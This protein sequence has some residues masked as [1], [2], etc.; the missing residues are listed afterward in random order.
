MAKKKNK[1]PLKQS[2]LPASAD[3]L[4]QDFI[5]DIDA[6]VQQTSGG[7][8]WEKQAALYRQEALK[9][10]LTAF[11]IRNVFTDAI[12]QQ[13][14][15][16]QIRDTQLKD[17][18]DNNPEIDESLL[19]P[20]IED[21]ATDIMKSGNMTYREV[22]G[23]LA[24]MNVN[25]PDYDKL[26]KQ[27]NTI[28]NNSAQLKLD[29]TKL[30]A[31]KNEIKA[32]G[33]EKF[34][35]G[36][37]SEKRLMYEDIMYG[38]GE[39]FKNIDGKLVWQNPGTKEIIGI[40]ETKSTEFDAGSLENKLKQINNP[41]ISYLDKSLSNPSRDGKSTHKDLHLEGIINPTEEYAMRLQQHLVNLGYNLGTTGDNNDGVDGDWGKLSKAA[42]KLYLEEREKGTGKIGSLIDDYRKGQFSVT[43]TGEYEPIEVSSMSGDINSIMPDK[44]AENESFKLQMQVRNLQT[45]DKSQMMYRIGIM[46]DEI[47][48]S[49]IKSLLFDGRKVILPNGQAKIGTGLHGL[50]DT[51]PFFEEWYAANGITSEEDKLKEYNRIR[52]EGIG[53]LGTNGVSV[54]DAFAEWYHDKVLLPQKGG[55]NISL[56]GD[57][58]S[59]TDVSST[60]VSGTDASGDTKST[61][62]SNI[63]AKFSY[64]G[65]DYTSNVHPMQTGGDFEPF[66]SSKESFGTYKFNTNDD[67]AYF[68][69]ST[70]GKRTTYTTPISGNLMEINRRNY[71]YDPTTEKWYFTGYLKEGGKWATTRKIIEIASNKWSTHGLNKEME[72]WG[73]YENQKKIFNSVLPKSDL[74][75][76]NIEGGMEKDDQTVIQVPWFKDPLYVKYTGKINGKHAYLIATNNADLNST[77]GMDAKIVNGQVVAGDSG[78]ALVAGD[79]RKAIGIPQHWLLSQKKSD[80][81]TSLDAGIYHKW[82]TPYKKEEK[83]VSKRKVKTSGKYH[84]ALSTAVIEDDFLYFD[85]KLHP[86]FKKA[87]NDGEFTEQEIIDIVDKVPGLV[88]A[89]NNIPLYRQ[90]DYDKYKKLKLRFL[91]TFDNDMFIK[92]LNAAV[93]KKYRI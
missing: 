10:V 34:T 88:F 30:L 5:G 63:N 70:D 35:E 89:Y 93:A 75:R 90:S 57:D 59:S 49:G 22:V 6:Y 39:N 1:T 81:K 56:V 45:W 40:D 82:K 53:V 87:I 42:M 72:A 46:F 23:K 44:L 61:T 33:F 78:M 37:N 71:L 24:G 7:N 54:K 51:S 26:T 50:P 65:E 73:G 15:A 68:L 79:F 41:S 2:E 74:Q 4:A 83:I 17:Y 8:I 29:N 32:Q 52:E 9:P 76:F 25:H 77:P 11:N 14:A 67:G 62:V 80:I 55:G 66:Y 19:F 43:T 48:D 38:R 86:K 60:D 20:G 91:D 27:L 3:M 13:A 18:L 84:N 12:N 31:I 21:V 64:T 85:T 69:R 36:M 58:E 92:L 47:E 16:E 28:N